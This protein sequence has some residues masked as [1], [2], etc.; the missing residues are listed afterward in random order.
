[1]SIDQI[2]G[3][4]SDLGA[5]EVAL[6]RQKLNDNSKI[7][8]NYEDLIYEGIAAFN[9]LLAGFS[10]KMRESPDLELKLNSFNLFAEVKH[11]RYKT[12]DKLDEHNTR[13]VLKNG[14]LSIYGNTLPTENKNSWDEVFEVARN[15]VS[16]YKNS[17]P[18]ILV[19]ASSSGYCIDDAIIPT[20][21][22]KINEV[23]RTSMDIALR[24]LNGVLLLSNSYSGKQKRNAW[25]FETENAFIA[26]DETI[27]D[28]LN[29]IRVWKRIAS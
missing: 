16:Q 3:V 23:S 20:A 14:Y 8:E 6:Y 12:Q 5:E 22:H 4:L 11:F 17:V 21:I 19:L 7:A 25:F 1:M 15:K 10:V 29:D 18:N 27:R 26:L 9:F 2:Y 24:K 13:E 28:R